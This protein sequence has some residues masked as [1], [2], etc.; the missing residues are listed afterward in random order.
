MSGRSS[1]VGVSSSLLQGVFAIAWAAIVAIATVPWFIR[2]LG[3]EKYGLLGFLA[4]L[5]AAISLLDLG[6]GA[7]INREVARSAALDDLDHARRLLRS[8]EV[9]YVAVAA[10]IAIAL[11]SAAPLIANSWLG[12]ST[13]DRNEIHQALRLM[14]VVVA[15]RWPI[16]LYMGTLVGLHRAQISYRITATMTTIGNVG[17]I[18]LLLYV[19]RTLW[20]YF[21]WQ[22]AS[23]LLYVLWARQSAWREL[24]SSISARLDWGLLK[25][26]L[27]QSAMMSGVAMSGLILTQL[28]KFVVS[29]ST[30]L[31]DFGRYVLASVLPMGLSVLIIPT[32]N[33]IY[34]RLSALVAAGDLSEQIKYYRLGTRLF[35]S[36]LAPIALSAFFYSYDLLALWTGNSALAAAAAPIA[37]LLCLGAA[38]N[39]IMHFPYALQLATG[40][41]KL[42]FL[43]NCVLLVIMLPLTIVLVRHYGAL[44]GAIAWFSLNALYVVIGVNVTHIYLLP[45]LQK[46]WVLRDVAPALII[47]TMF[48]FAG[49]Y[50]ASMIGPN[51]FVRLVV[52]TACSVAATATVLFT[53]RDTRAMVIDAWRVACARF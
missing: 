24:G 28:D 26:V 47:A 18:L 20:A 46:Q 11:V 5:Q 39:G 22:A 53:Y 37:G 51:H 3:I 16:S 15:L 14:G 35:L 27:I 19:D 13:L 6:L 2:L 36:C 29:S 32:F 9:V 31:G 42:P 41:T 45:G 8:L 48:V 33:V 12:P 17:A 1:R 10:I 43:I 50:L 25:G 21:I 7:T 44:G 34:P 23:S 49:H 38:L 40:Q 30:A 52:A 4:T